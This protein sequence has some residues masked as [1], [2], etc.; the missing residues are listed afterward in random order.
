M[1]GTSEPR[2]AV[3]S[4]AIESALDD[5]ERALC[6]DRCHVV[7]S[8]PAGAATTRLVDALAERLASSLRV[9]RLSTPPSTEDDLCARILEELGEPPGSD[10]EASLTGVARQL[11]S[12]GSALALLIGDVGA[13][14]QPELRR[15]GRLVALSK[16][17]LR[18]ALVARAASGPQ[19]GEIAPLMS[20]LGIGAVKVVL[21]ER[22]QPGGA[23]LAA[24]APLRRVAAPVPRTPPVPPPP[25]LRRAPDEVR[26]VGGRSRTSWRAA[27]G[28]ALALSLLAIRLLYEPA[29]RVV[30]KT[31]HASRPAHSRPVPTEKPAAPAPTVPEQAAVPPPVRP[32]PRPKAQRPTP[33]AEAAEV[34]SQTADIRPEPTEI[35]SSQAAE[36]PPEPAEVAAP[37]AEVPAQPTAALEEP[38][39]LPAAVHDHDASPPASP[40]PQPTEDRPIDDPLLGARSPQPVP[41]EGAATE[42][43]AQPAEVP[44]EIRATDE[45]AQAP[46]A[47][48]VQ[49][50]INADPWARVHVDGEDVGV[51]PMA[52]LELAPGLHRFRVEFPDGRVIERTLRVDTLRAAFQFP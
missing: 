9:V 22:L 7:V 24:S 42:E 5:L 36:I 49:V 48:K 37:P 11:A 29:A 8:A 3:R 18:L 17:G 32:A 40:A 15:M 10:P 43:I 20:A 1:T 2:E 27:Q 6:R 4:G 19:Q 28:L 52:D 35:P 33:P 25:A 14:T 13:W 30:P 26:E 50:S 39:E 51:T 38:A 21:D 16:P 31:T 47:P 12:R 34:P 44:A 41:G 45:V 23:G 46:D